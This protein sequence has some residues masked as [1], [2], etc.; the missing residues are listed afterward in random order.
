MSEASVAFAALPAESQHRFRE[1]ASAQR[2]RARVTPSRL[3]AVL[4]EGECDV[5]GVGPLGMS[6]LDGP[7]PIAA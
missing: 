1:R 6:S 7:F 4:Q 3:D 2:A 5:L